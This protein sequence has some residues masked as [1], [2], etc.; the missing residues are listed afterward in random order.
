MLT[1]A[2][3]ANNRIRQL[4]CVPCPIGYFCSSGAPVIC[5]PGSFCPFSSINPTPCQAGSFSGSAGASACSPC[6]AGS[7]AWQTGTVKCESC[8]EGHFCPIGSSMRLV[9]NCGF[10][11]YC[12]EGSAAPIACPITIPPGGG[13]WADHDEESQGPAFIADT[14]ACYEL[15]FWVEN[16]DGSRYGGCP[17]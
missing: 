3:K 8:P 15:C 5:P 14:A 11:N 13:S 6:P 10:G 16:G 17:D 9:P 12:P 1:F 7:Y 4:T 2:D